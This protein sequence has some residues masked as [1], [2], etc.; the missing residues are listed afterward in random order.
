MNFN[1]AINF[2][3]SL[4]VFGIKPGIDRIKYAARILGNPQN[5]YK[6]LHI[7]GTKGKGSTTTFI[8][9]ILKEANF[10]VGT[11]TSP[12]VFVPNER[13]QFNLENISDTD[14]ACLINEIKNLNNMLQKSEH[15]SLTE[16]E[17]KTLAAFLYFQKKEVDYAVIETGMGGRFDATNIIN[18]EISIITTI[19]FDHMEYLGNSINE[20]AYEKAGI[21]KDNTICITGT[22][23]EAYNTI[24]YV[25]DEKKSKLI[26]LGEDFN[27]ETYGSNFNFYSKNIF[28]EDIKPCLKGS[29]QHMN[30]SLAIET[31]LNLKENIS[32]ESIKN[33]VEK[34][35][36][37]GRF[38]KLSSTPYV[39][40]DGAHNAFSAKA[41]ADQLK[42]L[43]YERLILIIGMLYNHSCEDFLEII[44]PYSNVI[45]AT[46]SSSPKAASEKIISTAARKFLSNVIETSNIAEAIEKAKDI[47]NDKDLILITGSFYTIGEVKI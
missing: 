15:N 38:Q 20:I 3:N 9:S 34:A 47:Y 1:E 23:G 29:F 13:I 25:A 27:Y 31:V 21:I 18:P 7:A 42:K 16:F 17:A 43:K 19:D 10:K 46:K 35:F 14:F 39:I 28:I 12:Y 11:Y 44:A 2:L 22:F 26:R 37:P 40:I 36:L 32:L 45:I 5:S 24:K 6:T 30:A 4:A 33:G 41:L 8:S